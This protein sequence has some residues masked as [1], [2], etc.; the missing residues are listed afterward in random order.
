[1]STTALHPG[2]TCEAL[3]SRGS[4]VLRCTFALAIVLLLC[5]NAHA[6]EEEFDKAKPAA[7]AHRTILSKPL[8]IARET[9]ATARDFATFRDPAW[10]ALTLAQIGAASA[11]AVTSLNALQSCASCTEDG[12]SRIFVGTR[13][14]AHKYIVAGVLEIGIEAVTAHY[15]LHHGPTRKWYWRTLWMLPQ[16]F[17]LYEHARH[18]QRNPTL[19][20]Q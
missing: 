17:S 4:Q 16:S 14:D 3:A 1:M 13:P 8:G 10:S 19:I 20:P 18:S 15:F 7:P 11:D 12:L 9:G 5:G 6:Q 2:K